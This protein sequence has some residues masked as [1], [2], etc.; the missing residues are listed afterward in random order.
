VNRPEHRTKRIDVAVVALA[1][2]L[3]VGAAVGLG[4]HAVSVSVGCPVLANGDALAR[5]PV[6]HVFFLIKENHAFENYFGDRPGVLGFPPNGTFRTSF[7]SNATVSPFALNATGTPD[8]PHTHAAEVVDV[9]GGRL[10]DFV[11][12]AAA[13]GA[14]AP[15]DA[16]GYY[17]PSAIAP[18]VA[19]ADHYALADRF[20]TGVLGPTLPNRVFDL[21][22]TS[23]NWSSDAPPPP[24]TFDFPTILGQLTSAGIPWEYD[25]A[26]IPD[27]LA[28][29]L[30]P[31]IAASPCDTARIVPVADLPA[32]LN[33]STP[34]AVTFIDPSNDPTVS[35]HPDD[36]VT[37]GA[38]WSATVV[39]DILES[40]VGP[41][42][43]IFLFFDE[44]GGFWDPVLPPTYGAIGDGLR[45]PLLVVSPWTPSGALLQATLDPA[46]LLRFVDANWGL[47]FLNARVA[48][49]PPLSGAFDFSAP[50]TPPLLL[51][52]NVWLNA[53]TGAPDTDVAG[54]S[55]G[56][57]KYATAGVPGVWMVAEWKLAT[58]ENPRWLAPRA[59]TGPGE[60]RRPSAP[61]IRSPGRSG[62]SRGPGR[63]R[64]TGGDISDTP[65]R[66]TGAG[67]RR[68][69]GDPHVRRAPRREERQELARD[70][71]RLP[72]TCARE[73]IG[74]SG[75]PPGRS[76]NDPPLGIP[77]P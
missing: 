27:N 9:D 2:V 75:N 15:D 25:Y 19:Y 35:E 47:P 46:A 12:E 1:C 37:F 20:F 32:Q 58:A 43:V 74:S 71:S 68:P 48:A 21:A 6:Q 7:D 54:S 49:A 41:S 30:I 56:P 63:R 17:P 52:T 66:S 64:R 28:P 10:D 57:A 53:G 24:G 73:G 62:R 13:L 11:A 45:V 70:R 55:Q 44:A 33:S 72:G 18:Y 42:S 26:G 16:V 51:P 36:N 40:R 60:S 29:D 38:D 8:L 61:Q 14:T 4:T 77:K 76:R 50:P 22:A 59:R 3:T 34:P 23:G 65:I 39:N 5:S 31:A 67:A 69:P